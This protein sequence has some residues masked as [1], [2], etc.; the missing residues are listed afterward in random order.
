ML[1]MTIHTGDAAVV[2]LAEALGQLR[3]LTDTE[4]RILHRALRRDA[5]LFRR[6]TPADDATL[7]KAHRARIRVSEIATTLGR[8]EQ[9]VYRRLCDLKK[10]EKV[11]GR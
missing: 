2:Y 3:A 11:R 10:R 8:T 6:W 9:A 4:S 7:L 1:D 5:G